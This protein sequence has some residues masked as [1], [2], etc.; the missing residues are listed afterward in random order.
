[1]SQTLQEQEIKRSELQ[2]TL[3]ELAEPFQPS[4]HETVVKNF[5]HYQK[6]LTYVAVP[7]VIRRCNAKLL[8]RGSLRFI[9]LTPMNERFRGDDILVDCRLSF[10]AKD[11]QEIA[12]DQCGGGKVT[13]AESD[14][15]MGKQIIV[16]RGDP[17]DLGFDMKSAISDA[18]KKCCTFF[19]IGLYLYEKEYYLF[20]TLEETL[21]L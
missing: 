18:F 16:K 8:G 20:L 14:I 19:G 2:E 9:V 6:E 4:D 13:R 11:G 3:K 15:L 12:Y 5:G 21:S 1:M 17:I 10:V 7:S